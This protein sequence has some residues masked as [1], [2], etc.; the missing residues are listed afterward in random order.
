MDERRTA[1][2]RRIRKWRLDDPETLAEFVRNLREGVYVTDAEGRILDANP[3]FLEMF[4]VANV[5]E[6]RWYT[7]EQLLVDP[8]RR[9][10]ELEILARDGSIREF[11]LDIRRPDGQVRTVLD[12]AYRVVDESTGRV[13]F[14]GILIDISDRKELEHQ[15]RESSI[16]D[17][18][19]G[20]FNRRYLHEQEV[21]LLEAAAPWGAIVIDIDHF[22]DYNDRHGHHTGDRVLV[23]IAR[24]L[25][26]TVRA[27]DAV[28]RI[29]GDE[30][31]VLVPNA[32]D[33]LIAEIAGRLA[34]QGPRQAPVAF[35]LGWAV[36]RGSET[37]EETI[38]R[39]D[40]D[41]ITIRA[42]RRKFDPERG[43]SSR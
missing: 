15:L 4:G 38:R 34:E 33:D 13:F 27:E 20:C 11:E 25:T 22:K 41:L 7:A 21:K 5:K 30:F 14:H 42:R 23:E 10:E 16:R 35:S 18:L 36:R 19:T 17:A 12:T 9:D 37:L 43:S 6:L 28:I 40:H 32:S 3:A 29:G 1:R 24:F 8:A 31:L 2:A 39:A 26:R